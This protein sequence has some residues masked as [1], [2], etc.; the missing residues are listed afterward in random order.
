MGKTS[1]SKDLDENSLEDSYEQVEQQYVGKEQVNTKHDDG[2]PL[3][4]GWCLVFIQHRTLGLQRIA[5]IHA[6]GIYV[7][8]SVCRRHRGCFLSRNMNANNHLAIFHLTTLQCFNCKESNTIFHL[9]SQSIFVG[10]F[11]NMMR[12][13]S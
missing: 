2:E 11:P 12:Y 13:G 3:R 7:K 10:K 1:S 4:E 8:R 9:H 5:A 6:A